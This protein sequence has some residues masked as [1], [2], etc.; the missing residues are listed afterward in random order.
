MIVENIAP[1]KFV[2]SEVPVEERIRKLKIISQKICSWILVRV[3]W[4][5]VHRF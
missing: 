4:I 5:E 3:S 2:K 1:T